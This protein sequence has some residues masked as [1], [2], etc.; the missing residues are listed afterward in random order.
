MTFKIKSFLTFLCAA[1][2]LSAAVP[3]LAQNATVIRPEGADLMPKTSSEELEVQT[4]DVRD[5][6]P[7]VR[8]T[9]DK[10]ELITLE[11]DASS[12]IVGN[13]THL[14]VLLDT[15]RVLVLVPRAPGASSFTVLDQ[16][17]NVL[18]QRQVIVGSPKETYIRVR[19]SCANAED[20]RPCQATSVYYCPDMCHEVGVTQLQE[21]SAGD[22]EE[23]AQ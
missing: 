6:H 12:V 10:S 2:I 23:D 8:M 17:R 16:D 14:G 20:D 13:P 22:D 1:F 3:A 4:G 5:T 11:S 21:R 7:P 19:R 9:P 18:M 15:S